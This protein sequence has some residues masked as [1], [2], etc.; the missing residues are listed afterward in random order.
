[1]IIAA[2][3]DMETVAQASTAEEALQEY[4][5]T[6]PDV[7]LMD[8]RLPGASGTEALIAIRSEFPHAKIMMLTT[9]SGDIEI[10]RALRAGATAYVLK[11]T[12]KNELLRIIRTVSMGRKHIPSDVGSSLA[13][14]MGQEDLTPRE[15]EVLELIR[16][17]NKNKQIADQLGI[18]ETT[19]NFHIKNIVDKLQANDRTHAVTIALRRGLLQI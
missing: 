19:V 2:E 1:M 8:Q 12:P 7:I 11:S 16:E 15:L 9:S 13:E 3:A 6:R 4:R 18:S 14:H 17:G 5:R 10:Q